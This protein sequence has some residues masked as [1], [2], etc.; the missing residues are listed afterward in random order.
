[1]DTNMYKLMWQSY[2]DHL[3]EM[4][5]NM[6]QTDNFTD[7]TLVTDDKK[8][9][10]AHRNILSA[11]SPVL[12]DILLKMDHQTNHPFIYLKGIQ[13]SEMESILQFIYQGEARFAEYRLNEFIS[14]SQSLEITQ[15]S[16]NAE[17]EKK[18]QCEYVINE[19]YLKRVDFTEDIEENND[20][21]E[22]WTQRRDE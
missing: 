11:C 12:N 6:M 8:S 13:S 7:V 10:K 2:P 21:N 4:M 22:D 9:I 3:R 20:K 17:S 18:Q 16:K 14:A 1:M 15:L 5:Q 19:R